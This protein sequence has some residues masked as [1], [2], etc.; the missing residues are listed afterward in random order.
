MNNI[1]P[2]LDQFVRE[3]VAHVTDGEIED[4]VHTHGYQRVLVVL[5]AKAL[6]QANANETN[7]GERDPEYQKALRYLAFN[8]IGTADRFDY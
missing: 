8:L 1:D 4:A 2:R 6:R 3:H 7:E 5:A